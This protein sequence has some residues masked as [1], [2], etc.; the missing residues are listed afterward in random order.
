MIGKSTKRR[1]AHGGAGSTPPVA[2]F[3]QGIQISA[4]GV[5]AADPQDQ[6][7]TVSILRDV[8]LQLNH[9][10]TAI[11]GLNGSG[12]STV[13]R[14]L[15]GLVTPT[16]GHV[17]V[18]GI[19]VARHWKIARRIVGFVFTDPAAQL[20]MPTAVEDVELS[21]RATFQDPERRHRRAEELLMAAG[22][23]DHMHQSV[24]D[25]SG[26]QRQLVALTSVLAVD[27][28]VLVLDE[29]TTLLDLRNRARLMERLHD[30]SQQLVYATH[31][32]ELAATA[33]HV[34]VIHEGRVY[35]Q[36]GPQLVEDYHTWCVEGFP[37]VH[38]T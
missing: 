9:P 25:L 14:L 31:D 7:N 2:D 33:H 15:N 5:N 13:L 24:Y 30:L 38:G 20:L 29:P 26:G 28:S 22:L 19:D 10:R 21:L 27:P 1:L 23:K 17:Q 12:K 18:H 36:G 6:H 16:T 32:L 34:V 8:T 11:V 35:A 4:V 3:A 37:K